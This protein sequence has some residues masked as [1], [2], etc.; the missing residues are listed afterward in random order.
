MKRLLLDFFTKRMNAK[1]KS[2]ISPSYRNAQC[3]G[4]IINKNTGLSN[5]QT[6]LNDLR[7]DNKDVH[8]MYFVDSPSDHGIESDHF[9]PE[10]FNFFGKV[11]SRSERIIDFTRKKYDYIFV[12]DLSPSTYIDYLTVK[13]NASVNIGFYYN[14]GNS[15]AD[16][17]IKPD[18]GKELLDLLRYTKQLS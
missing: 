4:V 9:S 3:V 17:Q 6:F 18:H 7:N 5:I 12:L 8:V 1:R 11:K 10:D 15:L 14:E 13:S 2:V 16:L